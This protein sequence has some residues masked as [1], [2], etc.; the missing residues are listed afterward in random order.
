MYGNNIDNSAKKSVTFK[1]LPRLVLHSDSN[2]P[3]VRINLLNVYGRKIRLICGVKSLPWLI[4]ADSK[5]IVRAEGITYHRQSRWYE[6][7]P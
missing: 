5:R 3:L 4:L 1:L 7:G 6:E 2:G